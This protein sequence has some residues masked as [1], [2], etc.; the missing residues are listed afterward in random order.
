MKKIITSMLFV[1]LISAVYAQNDSIEYNGQYI[2][3]NGANVAWVN[4]AN[5]IG[6]GTTDFVSFGKMFRQ[7]HDYGANCMR[8]WLHTT[9]EN[10]PEFNG[11]TVISPGVG[12]I[13]DLRQI[14]DSAYKNDIGLIL[15]LWSFDMLDNSRSVAPR[16]QRLLTTDTL[17]SLYIK[18]SLI[19]MVD[20]LKGNPGIIAWEI[21]NEPEGMCSDVYYGGWSNLLHISIK[22]VQKF[23][24]RCAGAI[25]RTDPGAKVTNG[26]WTF[27]AS[28]DV[29]V[30]DTNYYSDSRLIAR[31]G[32]PDGT[33]DFYSVHFYDGNGS[34]LSP[35][36]HP[37]SYWNLDKP[38]VI[39]EF[40][41]HCQYCG[42]TV[43]SYENLFNTGYAGALGWMWFATDHQ[44]DI[45]TEMQYML[46]NHT[47]A[48]DINRFLGNAPSITVT[49]PVSGTDLPSGSDVV[50]QAKAK[51][52]DGQVVKVEFWNNDTV[53]ATITTA[54]YDYTWTNVP[55]GL[56]KFYASVTDDSNN[57]KKT[58]PIE[59]T[60]GEP[61]SYIYEAEEA[62][63]SGN[64]NIK[65]DPT[66]S[67]GEY[68]ELTDGGSNT[69]LQWLVPNVPQ[70][71]S[72]PLIMRYKPAYGVKTQYLST[73]YDTV[74]QQSVVF[75]GDPNTWLYDTAKIYLT[76]D[77]ST[78]RMTGFWGW[79]Q[80][81][82]VQLP[83]A[84]PY[85]VKNIYVWSEGGISTI[86][87]PG[88]T[89]QLYANVEPN[90]AVDTTITWS[91]NKPSQASITQNGLVTA[92]ANGLVTVFVTANDGSGVTTK[93]NVTITN[94]T[95]SISSVDNFAYNLYP[96]PV[97]NVLRI[98]HAADIQKL[99]IH[100]LSGKVAIS[101]TNNNND[102]M[103]VDMG[104]LSPGIYIIQIFDKSGD[105]VLGKIV[106][107]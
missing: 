70:T 105:I 62:K 21:F 88:G 65:S 96:N 32:D 36:L 31:G 43:S 53:L 30:H 71:D 99:I 101:L 68:V 7:A 91:V 72:F 6:P 90:V 76:K 60:V 11:D 39:A 78:I 73:N 41:P 82:Y 26:A 19:P 46:D 100:D 50:F 77:T 98:D 47:K 66:A 75:D 93:F 104:S 92:L 35:F 9:G 81:D 17:T 83:F 79:M 58:D 106:K 4:F 27:I 44:S 20:S 64:T 37:A 25:H 59:V 97:K 40:Y 94:Q 33:L 48:V 2:F 107:E 87:T 49:S 74:N 13:A 23:V 8:L 45:K 54:P 29:G 18:N 51:D 80:L 95:S 1:F 34:A 89:L 52:T 55:D 10:T 5:D 12:A 63:L 16:N 84:R 24:N 67:N 69:Y 15:C 61:P 56:Y 103:A 102:N 14:I 85:M 22:N 86:S 3:L 57:V 38:I 42:D 28:S